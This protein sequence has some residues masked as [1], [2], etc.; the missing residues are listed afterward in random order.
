MSRRSQR[1]SVALLSCHVWSFP[2]LPA[3][4]YPDINL[5]TSEIA[6]SAR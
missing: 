1:F 4:A 6:A 5:D 3:S 2:N